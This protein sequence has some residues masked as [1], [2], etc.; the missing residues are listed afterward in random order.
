M[1]EYLHMYIYILVKNTNTFISNTFIWMDNFDG[2][3]TMDTY[4]YHTRLVWWLHFETL[5]FKQVDKV[6]RSNVKKNV[7]EVKEH[8]KQSSCLKMSSLQKQEMCII[9]IIF[10]IM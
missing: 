7:L 8:C 3:Y 9:I 4:V 1:D 5:M 10:K 2:K 6:G